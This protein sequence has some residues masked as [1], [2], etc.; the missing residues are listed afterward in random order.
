MELVILILVSFS[1]LPSIHYA[2]IS[3]TA[4]KQI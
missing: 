1:Y 2:G 3:R 4:D